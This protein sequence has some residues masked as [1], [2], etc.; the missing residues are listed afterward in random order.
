M[1]VVQS[2]AT[3]LATASLL[4]LTPGLDTA[5]ILRTAASSGTRPAWFA[6]IGIGMGCL[7]WG[8]IVAVGLGALLAASE[9]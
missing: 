7:A 8:M 2:L 5:M 6:A 4:T 3:F 9:I 1:S